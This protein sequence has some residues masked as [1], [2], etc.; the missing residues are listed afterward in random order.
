MGDKRRMVARGP[1][2]VLSL[3]LLVQVSLPG[4]AAAADD[5]EVRETA[6]G[7]STSNLLVEVPKGS[8]S[9]AKT[10][11]LAQSGATE[12][13][14][15]ATAWVPGARVSVGA[16][17][18]VLVVPPGGRPVPLV[19][20]AD[21]LL[22]PGER[23][24]NVVFTSNGVAL[25]SVELT[26]TKPAA[27]NLVV[28]KVSAGTASMPFGFWPATVQL[29]VQLHETSGHDVIVR[30]PVLL[31]LV[32]DSGS[33]ETRFRS[34]TVEGV[35]DG[36]VWVPGG[37]RVDVVVN[38]S[39][40]KA[41]AK[42]SA[43]LGVVTSAGDD[44]AAPVSFT[45]SRPWW[46]A[47]LLIALGVA[48]SGLV[49]YF[50]VSRRTLG[51]RLQLQLL[52]EDP[53]SILDRF[54]PLRPEETEVVGDVRV[55]IDELNRRM[56]LGLLPKDAH[57]DAAAEKIR[58]LPRYVAAR[59]R[60]EDGPADA[61][62][63]GWVGDVESY[64]S[65]SLDEDN[66]EQLCQQARKSLGSLEAAS[67]QAITER[68]DRVRAEGTGT[69]AVGMHTSEAKKAVGAGDLE[70]AESELAAAR[71]LFAADRL[72]QLVQGP[73]PIGVDDDVWQSLRT[74]VSGVGDN[75]G[76]MSA[77]KDYLVTVTRGLRKATAEKIGQLADNP[78]L[79]DPLRGVADD[80][81]RADAALQDDR[82]ESATE[83]YEQARNAYTVAAR[84]A[85]MG[86]GTTAALA[87]APVVPVEPPAADGS[88]PARLGRPLPA[89]RIRRRQVWLDV[90]MTAILAVVAVLLGLQILY[91]PEPAWGNASHLLIAV[92]WGLGLHP[93]GGAVFGGL[94]GIRDR[95]SGA[96][97]D[98]STEGKAS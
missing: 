6:S 84:G 29:H 11:F 13:R 8:N 41:P 45:V 82:I 95:I 48:L 59:R 7:D 36:Q 78:A 47:M 86:N 57:L 16:P 4:E 70:R 62:L 23:R 51:Q 61:T 1:L 44:V 34:L 14:V 87:D 17:G 3:V 98:S 46:L 75:D 28:E 42:Y 21:D 71:H 38:V 68:I 60:T 93:V 5:V 10:V 40:V 50:L 92:L 26:I 12:L 54:R 25:G 37:Q 30:P 91:L 76:L 53:D 66:L 79:A 18:G 35:A 58:L 33:T 88:A 15:D 27:P 55:Q 20:T 2:L 90:L 39:E 81:N 24:G 89:A 52:S 69:P 73:T 85:R 65:A 97:A 83:H 9:V 56:S 32:N 74:R 43:Q 64:L 49:R 22:V 72:R 80:L 77:T 31:S 94:Q 63:Q 96:P 19:V 67:R